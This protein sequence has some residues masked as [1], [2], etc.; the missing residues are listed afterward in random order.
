[1]PY[2]HKISRASI[3]VTAKNKAKRLAKWGIKPKK[4]RVAVIKKRTA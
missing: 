1:M 2:L 3:S 4:L